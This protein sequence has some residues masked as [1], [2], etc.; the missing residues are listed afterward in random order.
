MYTLRGGFDATSTHTERDLA[1]TSR[2]PLKWA[3]GKRWQVPHLRPLWEPHL[4][5]RLVEPFCGGLQVAFD[6]GPR[7]ALLNDTNTHLSHFYGWLR[8]GLQIDLPMHNQRATFYRY[9]SRFNELLDQGCE[10]SAEAIT[11]SGWRF[12]SCDVEEVT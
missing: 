8:R 6:L 7:R 11:L 5:K 10:S 4:R 3:G 1:S 9:C 2:S 12:M